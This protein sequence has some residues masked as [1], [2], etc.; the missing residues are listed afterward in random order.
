MDIDAILGGIDE[1]A[2]MDEVESAAMVLKDKVVAAAL[3]LAKAL[4]AIFK[5]YVA[6]MAK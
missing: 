1:D 5:E 3:E 6:G 2:I 4:V